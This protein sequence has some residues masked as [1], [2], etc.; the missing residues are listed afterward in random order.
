MVPERNEKWHTD[1]DR[2]G[3]PYLK[4]YR[5]AQVTTHGHDHPIGS[6]VPTWK[7]FAN[8]MHRDSVPI[9]PGGNWA[10][11]EMEGPGKIINFWC[12]A[13]PT[14]DFNALE[15]KISLGAIARNW[16]S[17]KHIGPFDQFRNLL[18]NVW[19]EIY[20]DDSTAPLVNAPWVI[21]SAWVLVNTAIICPVT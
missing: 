7:E 20:F 1:D 4:D 19:V 15:E 13:T 10:F 12:T 16:D 9:P 5:V 3:L 21:F 8:T 6:L 17:I 18:K 11:P 2:H 14:L